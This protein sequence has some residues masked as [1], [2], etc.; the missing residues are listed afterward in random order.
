MSFPTLPFH[1]LRGL[2]CIQRLAAAAEWQ[3]HSKMPLAVVAAPNCGHTTEKELRVHPWQHRQTDTSPAELPFDSS[4]RQ[5]RQPTGI[6]FQLKNLLRFGDCLQRLINWLGTHAPPMESDQSLHGVLV[7][8]HGPPPTPSPRPSSAGAN[9]GGAATAPDD[10]SATS[11]LYNACPRRSS[12]EAAT[13]S[14]SE[15][16]G[17]PAGEICCNCATKP[18]G[19]ACWCWASK[20]CTVPR[21]NS[22]A[23]MMRALWFSL[24]LLLLLLLLPSIA[25]VEAR[26]GRL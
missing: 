22:K 5:R 21:A 4:P 26:D 24:A 7:L 18:V 9:C 15:P 14:K 6:G 16:A 20:D 10:S 2:I 12:S 8:H 3:I 11:M 17:E 25:M 23:E 13:A 1:Y 19:E